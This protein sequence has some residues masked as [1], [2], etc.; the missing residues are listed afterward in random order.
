MSTSGRGR[1]GRGTPAKSQQEQQG[2]GR[3][4]RGTTRRSRNNSDKEDTSEDPR[5]FYDPPENAEAD[6]QSAPAAPP[7]AVGGGGGGPRDPEAEDEEGDEDEEDEEDEEE[8]E[9]K[10]TSSNVDP[11]IVLLVTNIV[12]KAMQE[13][14]TS[15]H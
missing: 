7:A 10:A 11:R 12:Q 13:M 5:A 15:A 8:E 4:G 2:G 6:A 3:L 14:Q 9:D 1:G